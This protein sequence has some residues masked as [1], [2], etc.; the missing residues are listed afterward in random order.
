MEIIFSFT[1][2]ISDTVNKPIYYQLYECIK[3]EIISG[4]IKSDEKLPSL[5]KLSKHLQLSRNTIEAAYEQL[6]AEGYVKRIPKVGYIVEDIKTDLLIAPQ[7]LSDINQ[8]EESSKQNKKFKYD[9]APRYMD[10]TC[11]NTKTWKNVINSIIN[12]EFEKLLSYGDPQGEYEL[13]LELAKYVYENRGVHCT[14]DQIVVGAGTQYCLNLICQ[15]LREDFNCIAME[16]PGS[17]YIR[18]IFE[19]N[20]FIIDPINVNDDGLDVEQLEKSKCKIA[21]VT[22]SHQF[23]KGVI[24]SAKNRVKLLNWAHNNNG[25]IIEDDYD[26]EMRFVGKPIPSLKSLDNFDQVIYLGTLSKVFMPSLRIGYMVLPNWLLKLYL[27]KY[28][29]NEQT[30]SKLNQLALAQFMNKGYLQSHIRKMRKHYESKYNIINEAIKNHMSNNANLISSSCGMRV[31]LEIKTDYTEEQIV[32]LAEDAD[33]KII[34]ISQYYKA[35][36]NYKQN[37]RVRVLISYKG[38]P[39]EDIEPAIKALSHAWFSNI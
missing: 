3:E 24:M 16:E 37:G 34:P 7:V 30:T 22:P 14:P 35:K 36:E 28:K 18:Y 9:F 25:I 27:N 21:F 4:N 32:K 17:N 1:A 11:Y 39:I 26:S 29:M 8:I 12:K 15:L 20:Q 13:R 38:I 2:L 23:P 5:R 6:Y 31:I 10:K 19:R 33:V